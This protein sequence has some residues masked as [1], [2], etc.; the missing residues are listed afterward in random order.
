MGFLIRNLCIYNKNK[1]I[2]SYICRKKAN[3]VTKK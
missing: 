1:T 2:Y 3:L